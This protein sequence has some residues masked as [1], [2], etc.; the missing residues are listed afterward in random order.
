MY[1]VNLMT[2]CLIVW[3]Y[4]TSARNF[5][6]TLDTND[7]TLMQVVQRWDE[8]EKRPW[9]YW[10]EQRPFAEST[11]GKPMAYFRLR[12]DGGENN[13]DYGINRGRKSLY[14]FLD[15]STDS[16][17]LEDMD[18]IT[19]PPVELQY[20]LTVIPREISGDQMEKSYFNME[21]LSENR[22]PNSTSGRIF[23]TSQ[24]VKMHETEWATSLSSTTTTAT[25]GSNY[26]YY[27]Y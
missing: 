27:S 24:I 10:Y 18:Y 8:Y 13:D 11:E 9:D 25:I 26:R 16:N 22:N 1:N 17:E 7:M 2:V 23:N 5:A 12:S 15:R 14:L 6:K 20:Y 4:Y 21:K 19:D 3:R